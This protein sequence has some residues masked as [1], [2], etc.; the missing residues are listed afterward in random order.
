VASLAP[1]DTVTHQLGTGR[2]AYVYLIDGRARFDGE[3]A[4]TGDAAKVTDQPSL[5]VTA[6]APSELILVD[7]PLRFRPVG[8]WAGR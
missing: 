8:I 6:D 3:P 7:V 1:G 4:A 2:G 5:E